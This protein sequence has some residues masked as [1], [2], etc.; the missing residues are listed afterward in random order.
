VPDSVSDPEYVSSKS[1]KDSGKFYSLQIYRYIFSLFKNIY[2]ISI[3]PLVTEIAIAQLCRY[4][5]RIFKRIYIL[6]RYNRGQKYDKGILKKK[7]KKSADNLRVTA[8][9]AL[10]EQNFLW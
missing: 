10:S 2:D 4:R 3:W 8:G 9:K 1:K 6:Y 7:K 5:Y